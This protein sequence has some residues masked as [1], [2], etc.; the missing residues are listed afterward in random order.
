MWPQLSSAKRESV[1]ISNVWSLFL[2][3][4]SS[5]HSSPL[6]QRPATVSGFRARSFSCAGEQ[7]IVG[8]LSPWGAQ[9]KGK[10]SSLDE[11]RERSGAY[12]SPR[13]HLDLGGEKVGGNNN[14]VRGTMGVRAPE[15]EPGLHLHSDVTGTARSCGHPVLSGETCTLFSRNWGAARLAGLRIAVSTWPSLGWNPGLWLPPLLPQPGLG[16]SWACSCPVS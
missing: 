16:L 12:G 13:P 11:G 8:A 7:G 14:P 9:G 15:E 2:G 3:T 5:Q 1:R 10:Q 6:K 4:P